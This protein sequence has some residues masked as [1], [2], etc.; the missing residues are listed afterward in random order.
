MIMM[1]DPLTS[2]HMKRSSRISFNQCGIE[3]CSPGHFYGPRVRWHCIVHFVLEGQGK[4][5]VNQQKY[6]VHAG[7]AFLIPANAEGYYAADYDNPW[8]YFWLSFTGLEAEKY[9][10]LIFGRNVFVKKI[11]EMGALW[12]QM[13]QIAVAFIKKTDSDFV[14]KWNTD[15][16]AGLK[17]DSDFETLS[18]EKLH[19]EVFCLYAADT[20][21]ESLFLNEK[22]C[23]MLSIL[24]KSCQEGGK[25]GEQTENYVRKIKNYIDS[26][27][28]EFNEIKHI[29]SLFHIH[30]NY[31]NDIF[32]EAYYVS[33][34]RYLLNRKL[35]YANHLLAETDYT[36]QNISCACGFD[37]V[38]SFGKIYR[39]YMGTSPSEYRMGNR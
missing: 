18:R 39:K 37:S 23:R 5:I 28:T 32:K 8:K 7:E 15:S 2:I 25:E 6:E 12:E 9:C 38:S 26:Y 13:K 29:A 33:P 14:R 17:P 22:T 30:P 31:L 21:S 27:Y 24:L 4:L 35:E 10:S 36:I 11:S 16:M 20:L 1:Y 34:K 19:S 3:Y